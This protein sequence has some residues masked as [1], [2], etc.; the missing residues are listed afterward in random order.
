L[1]F[2]WSKIVVVFAVFDD[3]VVY[4]GLDLLLCLDGIHQVLTVV[5][6]LSQAWILG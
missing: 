6:D 1:V 5:Y 2:P 4:L 3:S